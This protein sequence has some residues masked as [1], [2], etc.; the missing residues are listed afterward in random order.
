MLPRTMTETFTQ[1]RRDPDGARNFSDPLSA[2]VAKRD[3][4]VLETDREA[5][6]HGRTAVAIPAGDR[7][8]RA[9]K[10]GIL[11]RSDPDY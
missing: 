2:A 9:P 11:R 5:L 1:G 10:C 8:R 7:S 6:K 3:A 4:N